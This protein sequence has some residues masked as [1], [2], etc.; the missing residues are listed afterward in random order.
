MSS[1]ATDTACSASRGADTLRLRMD[2]DALKP[3]RRAMASAVPYILMLSCGVIWGM[4]FSLA[5]I[6]ASGQAHPV[7][8]AFWQAFGG[9]LAL[10]V[11]VLLRRRGGRFRFHFHFGGAN[12]RHAC[13]IAIFGT[14]V[15]ATLYFYAAPEVPAGV[16][17]ITVALVPML[18]YALSWMLAIDRFGLWRFLGV[19]MGFL[20]MLLLVA[21]DASLPDPS[22]ARWLI[23]PLIASVCYTLENVYV[24]RSI[25]QDADMVG[26]LTGGLFVAALMLLPVMY[27]EEAFYPINLPLDAAETAM[28]AMMLVSSVAYIMFLLVIKMAGAVFASLAGY[29]ITLAGVFWGMVFF[30]ERHSLWVWGALALMLLGMVLV[31]PRRS[32]PDIGAHG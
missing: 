31:T 6:A 15:P 26:L 10:L 9:G 28:L 16:L 13:F 17:A 20:A 25:P 27:A 12:C 19:L 30:S 8:L 14:A 4:T 18:T 24:D 22:M 21:P 5:R 23:L 32:A 3:A 29:V 7:G 11:F 1:I 2:T